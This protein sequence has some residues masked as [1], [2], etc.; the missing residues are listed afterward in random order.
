MIKIVKNGQLLSFVKSIFTHP[1]IDEYMTFSRSVRYRVDIEVLRSEELLEV[2][3]RD[4]LLGH[5]FPIRNERHRPST[6]RLASSVS[7][8]I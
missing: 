3:L 1:I 5:D 8:K 6:Y 4:H 2:L 7:S